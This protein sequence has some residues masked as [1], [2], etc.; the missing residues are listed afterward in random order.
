MDEVRAM[1]ETNV[2]GVMMVTQEF[3]NLLIGSGDG[4]IV[5]IGLFRPCIAE[6]LFYKRIL[7]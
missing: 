4:L 1:F 7:L 3:L 6:Q 2:F 5:N